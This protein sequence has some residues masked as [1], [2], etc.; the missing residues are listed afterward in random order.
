MIS[1]T[2]ATA[3]NKF[4]IYF[5]A[6][7]FDA[8]ALKQKMKD[9]KK[10]LILSAF[11]VLFFIA[12][13]TNLTYADVCS[14]D[15]VTSEF[16]AAK[17]KWVYDG[18]TLLL[19]DKRK[20]RIIGIDTPEVKH[21]RQSAEA[22]GSKAREA[23]RELLKKHNYRVLL[24]Y[25][26]EKHDRYKRVLAH[27]FLPDKT[28]I[29]SW[30]LERGF[31]KTLSIPP[32]LDLADCYKQSERVAQRQSLKIWRLKSHQLKSVDNVSSRH[33]GYVRLKGVVSRV[34]QGKSIVIELVDSDTQIKISKSNVPYFKKISLG[35]L[36]DRVV[37]VS[38]VIK[39]RKRKRIL[40]L[41]HPSQL[42]I[43]PTNR[44]KPSIKWSM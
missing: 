29:S 3:E 6:G 19:S 38:G 10:A 27:V 26:K 18:D 41:S 34:K 15:N 16:E 2:S 25:G 1:S 33:K 43:I 37:I 7:M 32:N 17:V 20:I 44:I 8:L 31:A 4:N 13:F 14:S 36:K 5:L 9:L 12:P 23:L 35:R 42:E 24:K 21:H 39:K 40:Y 22:Y 30:L 11:F 28:N